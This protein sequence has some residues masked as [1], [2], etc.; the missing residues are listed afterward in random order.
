MGQP[1]FGELLT[2]L[3]MRSKETRSGS[4]DARERNLMREGEMS[5]SRKIT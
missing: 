3:K 4:M 2:R 5:G 1:G